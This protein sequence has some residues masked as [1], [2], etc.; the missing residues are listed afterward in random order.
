M[1]FLVL[2]AGLASAQ[3]PV[4]GSAGGP[5]TCIANVA[6]PTAARVEGR[7]ELLGDI[8]IQCTGGTLATPGSASVVANITVALANASVTSRVLGNNLSEALLLIDE[9]G[10]TLPGGGTTLAQTSCQSLVPSGGNFQVGSGFGGCVTYA[11]TATAGTATSATCTTF[12]GGVCTTF[13][14]VP[15]VFQGIVNGNQVVFNGVPILAPVSS[16]VARFFRITNIRADVSAI[17]STAGGANGT[18]PVQASITISNGVTLTNPVQTTAFLFNGL[19]STAVRGASNTGSGSISLQQCA[20]SGLTAGAV[21][22]FTEGFAN[23]FKT[24]FASGPGTAS[25]STGVAIPGNQSTPGQVLLGSESGFLFNTGSSGGG[26]AGLADFGT[27][28]KATFNNVPS[29]V[30]IF[31]STT[32]INPTGNVNVAIN[33]NAGTNIT[34]SLSSVLTNGTISTI[35]G[36][37]SSGISFLAGLVLSESAPSGTNGFLPLQTASNNAGSGVNIPVFGPLTVDAN[38]TATAVWE[39]LLDNPTATENAEFAVFYTLASNPATNTPPTTP[40]GTVSLSFAPTT[41]AGSLIPRFVPAT[42]SSTLITVSLC[43]TVLLFPFVNSTPG[44]DTG[45]AI[46]NTSADPYGTRQLGGN[47][48]LNFFGDGAGTTTTAT[49]PSAAT[50]NPTTIAP[51]KVWAEQASSLKPGFQGYVIADC[52]F[53]LAHGFAL[54][55]DTGIR[56]W[57][58]SYLPLVLPTVNG[59]RNP[60]SLLFNGSTSS[61]I[62]NI[63]H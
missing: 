39:V 49:F 51:G 12:T 18:Q 29:G 43:K 37:I 16:G 36:A 60:G 11:N 15:N 20:S 28:L 31:V 57:A 63:A 21:L 13:G 2:F 61:S 33:T 14:A 55:S 22:R 46:A 53:P 25:A 42:T 40:S 26:Y 34:S 56:N 17:G 1:A 24:R 7:T 10:T 52:N 8:V 58:T 35:P 19:G 54:F 4:S 9:P 30:N 6:N 47:C 48:T 59:N 38:G 44:F 3:L 45:I 50:G 23:S 62:E 32:N 5:L 27:R 41:T